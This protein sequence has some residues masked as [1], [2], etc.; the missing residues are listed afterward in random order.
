MTDLSANS[1]T[2]TER[3]GNT[4]EK[5]LP[6]GVRL[7]SVL[8]KEGAEKPYRITFVAEDVEFLYNVGFDKAPMPAEIRRAVAL[9]VKRIREYQALKGAQ[10]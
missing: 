8:H 5:L 2:I 10:A 1:A 4:V 9:A 3:I 7:Q 6:N